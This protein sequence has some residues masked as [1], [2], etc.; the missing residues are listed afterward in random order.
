MV[1]IRLSLVAMFTACA[2]GLT[3]PV[4]GQSTG[5]PAGAACLSMLLMYA[6][7]MLSHCGDPVDA[8]AEQ[9]YDETLLA[10]KT[11]IVESKPKAP[12]DAQ[13]LSK[14]E[15]AL[16]EKFSAMDQS[17]CQ[18]PEH[19]TQKRAFETITST[20][21]LAKLRESMKSWSTDSSAIAIGCL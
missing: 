15:Q 5:S 18:T 20:E 12:T 3:S 16:R 7:E 19:A 14:V 9:R 1:R 17:V 21:Y 8:S 4:A 11:F 10:L 6:H 2:I 13:P